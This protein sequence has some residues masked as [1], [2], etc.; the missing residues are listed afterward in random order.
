MEGYD[1]INTR[2]EI[3]EFCEETLNTYDDILKF[4]KKDLLKILVNSI[5]EYHK[6]EDKKTNREYL[7]EFKN[8]ASNVIKM[9]VTDKTSDYY[10]D[11]F[12]FDSLENF[13]QRSE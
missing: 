11:Q 6:L 9:R 2:R 7:R 13:K 8:V 12:F 10:E 1:L 4:T 3:R 5:R